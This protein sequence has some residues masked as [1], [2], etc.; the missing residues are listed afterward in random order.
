MCAAQ[1]TP[2]MEVEVRKCLG[3]AAW[4][5]VFLCTCQHPKSLEFISANAKTSGIQL[6]T[7]CSQKGGINW[8]T[9]MFLQGPKINSWSLFMVSREK[10]LSHASIWYFEKV[11][12]SVQNNDAPGQTLKHNRRHINTFGGCCSQSLGEPWS[13][14]WQR[15]PEMVAERKHLRETMK[16]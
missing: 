9:E 14:C 16:R 5:Q 11:R 6:D 1:G 13:L 12:F 7:I 4:T 3:R 2:L 10:I 15:I 8:R